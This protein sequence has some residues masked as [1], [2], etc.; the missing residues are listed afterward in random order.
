[1]IYRIY[2]N[3][4][5]SAVFVDDREWGEVGMLGR[6]DTG[7]AL[8]SEVVDAEFWAL[9][10]QD[11][12]W[13]DAEFDEVVSDGGGGPDRAG[14]APAGRHGPAPPGGGTRV[15]GTRNRAAVAYRDATGQALAA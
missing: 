8:G 15:V 12:E 13:L 4:H 10:C 7:A 14:T 5:T 1:V 3:C 2:T 6:G 11:E 9:V